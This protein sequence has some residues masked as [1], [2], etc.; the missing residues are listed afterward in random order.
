VGLDN[1]LCCYVH[2]FCVIGPKAENAKRQTGDNRRQ[3]HA[4]SLTINP[5]SGSFWDRAFNSTKRRLVGQFEI[6]GDQKIQ[7]QKM[8]ITAEI[9][10]KID[11]DV[12][13]TTQD[14][15]VIG[16]C[17]KGLRAYFRRYGLD[18]TSFVKNGIKVKECEF[19]DENIKMVYEQAMLRLGKDLYGR[20]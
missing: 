18:W 5:S 20:I 10:Y 6:V 8:I 15:H 2:Y 14:T 3:R 11:E 1:S 19:F 16:N 17:N 7:G 4:N 12:V 9:D 13:L